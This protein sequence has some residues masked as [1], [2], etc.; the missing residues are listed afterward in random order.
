M[1]FACRHDNSA[2]LFPE[3]VV[4]LLAGVIRQTCSVATV[5]NYAEFRVFLQSAL[6]SPLATAAEQSW[7]ARAGRAGRNELGSR[8][9]V[10]DSTQH[11][12][13]SETFTHFLCSGTKIYE[14]VMFALLGA[15]LAPLQLPIPAATVWAE[16]VELCRVSD[17]RTASARLQVTRVTS[18]RSNSPT[19]PYTS[20]FTAQLVK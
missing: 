18:T 17:S 19:L 14:K 20:D 7:P 12:S 6:L 2:R 3:T 1:H 8:L 13:R 11:K 16:S 15:R 5:M 10:T 9:P 4:E